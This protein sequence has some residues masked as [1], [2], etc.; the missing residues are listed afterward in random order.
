MAIPEL[1]RLPLVRQFTIPVLLATQ[2][3]DPAIAAAAQAVISQYNDPA[4][5]AQAESH[6]KWLAVQVSLPN[7]LGD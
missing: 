4:A 7:Q 3:A 1:E 5:T 6:L 2:S